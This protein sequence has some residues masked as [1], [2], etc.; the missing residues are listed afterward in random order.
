MCQ[1]SIFDNLA[2]DLIFDGDKNSY[3]MYVKPAR[4][5]GENEQAIYYLSK[6]F[7]DCES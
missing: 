5:V 3:G 1:K 6:K 4:W 7:N 2:P